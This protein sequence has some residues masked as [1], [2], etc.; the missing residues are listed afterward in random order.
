MNELKTGDFVYFSLSNKDAEKLFTY[1]G[2]IINISK[3][4]VSVLNSFYTNSIYNVPIDNVR[5]LSDK[6]N[7]V[8]E[9]NEH[10]NNQ[11][12]DY[13][14]KIKSVKRDYYKD[15]IVEKYCHL[16]QEIFNTAKH[17]IDSK[18]D[19][20]FE[21]KLKAICEKKKQLVVI[22]CDEMV[23]ARKANGAIKYKIKEL[24]NSR[25]YSIENLDKSI[26][27]LKKTFERE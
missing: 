25:N 10:Y 24:K 1:V 6:E 17:M 14:S 21:N 19:E 18:D 9:I 22:E 13:E 12:A 7:I 23:N 11:I 5:P 3:N 15:E 2:A 16:K 27:S 26:E 8:N 4:R 20:D